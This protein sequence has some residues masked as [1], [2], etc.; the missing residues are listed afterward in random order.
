MGGNVTFITGVSTFSINN[1]QSGKI[2]FDGTNVHVKQV[3]S[4]GTA[5]VTGSVTCTLYISYVK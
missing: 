3:P 4:A 2:T 1:G 5:T